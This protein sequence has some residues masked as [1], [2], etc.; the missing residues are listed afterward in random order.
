MKRVLTIGNSLADNATRFM[1]E[2]V[3]AEGNGLLRFGKANLGGCSL[4]KHWRLVEQCDMLPD[5]KPYQFRIVGDADE[6]TPMSLRETLSA[7]PWD[8]VTLQQVTGESWQPDTYQPW[9]D[10]LL[11]LIG[12]LA[13]Q[14]QPVVHQTWAYRSDAGYFAEI[15]IDQ[16]T[17]HDGLVKAYGAVVAFVP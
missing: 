3:A 16:Q 9:F 14:A 7:E 15:G 5:V 2:L 11:A 8:F 6:A 1:P 13:P 4:S 12:E 10:K 17:M